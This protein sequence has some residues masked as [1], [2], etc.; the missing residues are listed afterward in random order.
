MNPCS[1]SAVSEL[2]YAKVV[3]KK[4][5]FQTLFL[6][7]SFQVIASKQVLFYRIDRIC[8]I[9]RIRQAKKLNEKWFK[10]AACPELVE[11][12]IMLL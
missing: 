11:G 1:T 12:L 5:N 7:S 9:Y 10:I 6:A 4:Q 2:L 8:R 3:Q